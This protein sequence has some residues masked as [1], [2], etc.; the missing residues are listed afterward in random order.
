MLSLAACAVRAP[1]A[2]DATSPLSPDGPIAPASPAL[3]LAEDPPL[4]GEPVDGWIGLGDAPDGAPLT[5]ED[6]VAAALAAH[7][8]LR[9]AAADVEAARA[10]R[11]VAGRVPD[12]SIEA[13]WLPGEELEGTVAVDVTDLVIAPMRVGVA[14]ATLE[15]ERARAAA[16]AIRLAHDVRVAVYEVAAAEEELAIAQRALDAQAAARDTARALLAA[17]NVPALDAAAREVAYEKARVAVADLEQRR[18]EARV[19][20]ATLVPGEWA[21]APLAPVRADAVAD[22]AEARAVAANLELAARRHELTSLGRA[23]GVA[24]AGAWPEVEVGV[25]GVR[26]ADGEWAIGGVVEATI[27][28]FGQG[29]AARGAVVARLDAARARAESEALAVRA[30]TRLAADRVRAADA[31]AAHLRDV[32]LPL[33]RRVSAETLRQYDAMQLGI[34]ALLDAQRAEL[35]VARAEVE[36]RRA[37]WVARCALDALLAGVRVDAGPVS[38]SLADSPTSGGH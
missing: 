7:P 27:P 19:R 8:D 37:A 12:P 28:V 35:D 31:R 24:A 26:E 17:G 33:Q 21:I 30:A 4:P 15:A 22:D 16:A 32:V 38:V 14:D 18:N 29:V 11:V 3:A 36:A 2:F 25:R 9:A 20:F 1:A 5:V 6:A 23:A 10:L 34:F 13:E